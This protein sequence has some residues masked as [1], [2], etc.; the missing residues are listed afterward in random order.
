MECEKRGW[1]EGLEKVLS[2][3]RKGAQALRAAT[4]NN[5]KEGEMLNTF[6]PFRIS[7]KADC[8]KSIFHLLQSWHKRTGIAQLSEA[9][10]DYAVA[11]VWS[12]SVTI[13]PSLAFKKQCAWPVSADSWM[14]NQRPDLPLQSSI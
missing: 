5:A 12:S 10:T 6:S 14:S 3:P 13:K 9:S 4:K 8:K 7:G 2:S 11:G 1:N